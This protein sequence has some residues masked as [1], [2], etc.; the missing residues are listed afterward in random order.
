MTSK[1]I[2]V[3]LVEDHPA[4]REGLTHRINS[5]PDMTVCG[6]S[7]NGRDALRLIDST[8]T[9]VA[10]L[11]IGLKDMDG[12][13]VARSLQ[14]N[15]SQAKVV[16]HTM[17][18]EATYAERCLHLGAMGYVNKQSTPDEVIA[19]IR[20]VTKGDIYVS[21][22]LANKILT[23][24]GNSQEL[25]PMQ[26]LTDRQ[27]EIFRLI[28]EGKGA[29]QIAKQLHLSVHTIESHRENIKRKL[30]ITSSPELMRA[31]VLWAAK[32]NGSPTEAE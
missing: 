18:G 28:G 25:D 32:Q 23:R 24:R 14:Q 22:E 30:G 11:D 12:L 31:S 6:E 27:L 19:A 17:Y 1:Q 29:T 10:I 21:R 15:K 16:F 4:V 13:D 3:F 2:R 7:D 20:Q 5:Q 26:D 8:M 9:D